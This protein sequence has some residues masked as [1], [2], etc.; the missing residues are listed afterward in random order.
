MASEPKGRV[1]ARNLIAN[2]TGHGANLVVMFFLTPFTVH[3]LGQTEYGIW[4]LLTSLTGYMGFF[5]LGVRATT[6][7]YVILYLSRQE[8]QQVDETIRTNLGFFSLAGVLMLVAGVAVGLAFPVFF[9]TSPHEYHAM[10]AVLLP[11][12]A[13]NVWLSIVGAVFSSVLVAHN[14]FDLART[15]DLT[16]LAVRAGGT[17]LALLA[18]YGLMGLTLVAVACSLLAVAGNYVVARRIHPQLR[19]WPPALVRARLRELFGYGTAA[20]ISTNAP[21]AVKVTSEV[22]VGA[23][24]SLP[25]VTVFTVGATLI[26]YSWTFLGHIGQTFF[27]PVQRAAAI[28]DHESVRWYYLR[29][30][31]MGF[32]F[33]V[34]AYVGLVV[35]GQPFIALWMGGRETFL[36]DSVAQA[37]MVMAILSLSKLVTLPSIGGQ[38]LLAST[39]HIGYSAAVSAL[40]AVLNIG[41]SLVFILVAG[42]GLAGVALATLVARLLCSAVLIPWRASRVTQTRAA[43]FLGV[44]GLG[45]AATGA[46]AA[47]CLLVRSVVPGGSWLFFGLQVAA[48]LVGYVPIAFWLLVPRADRVRVLRAIRVMPGDAA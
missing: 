11:V 34:P 3:A 14:R 45:L 15:I 12:L 21:R 10:I 22:L 13:V 40:E 28:G 6:Q 20:F 46:F 39:G 5:D 43:R 36:E 30:I 38:P 33:G 25:A 7:R 27:P 29:Q 41:L 8:H 31:R 18:G 1:H 23:L 26:Y 19:V 47:W 35:F 42:W 44:L 4:S 17:V 2:W 24:I 37:A 32:I 9:P 16:V 48:S